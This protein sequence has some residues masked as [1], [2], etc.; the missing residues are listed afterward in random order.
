MRTKGPLTEHLD[1]VNR[2]NRLIEINLLF[3]VDLLFRGLRKTMLL[4]IKHLYSVFLV[5]LLNLN[6]RLNTHFLYTGI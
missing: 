2:M 4:I 5:F 1:H 6:Y 3:P